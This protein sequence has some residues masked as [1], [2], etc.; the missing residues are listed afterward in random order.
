MQEEIYA[1]SGNEIYAA[2]ERVSEYVSEDI[3][4]RTG[5]WRPRQH[6]LIH[7]TRYSGWGSVKTSALAGLSIRMRSMA[8]CETPLARI[9]GTMCAST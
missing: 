2:S 9:L 7:Q 6:Q 3:G 4:A 8:S 1:G 5:L